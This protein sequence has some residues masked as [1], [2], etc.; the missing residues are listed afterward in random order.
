MA[1]IKRA[2]FLY[3]WALL[4]LSCAVHAQIQEGEQFT[5]RVV[6]VSDGDTLTVQQNGKHIVVRLAEIDAPEPAQAYGREATAALEDLALGK[7]AVVTITG[8]TPG[9]NVLAWVDVGEF[10]LNTD[11]V[12]YGHAWADRRSATTLGLYRAERQAQEAGRGLWALEIGERVPPWEW[13]AQQGLGTTTIANSV[14][15]V[16]YMH[17][18]GMTDEAIFQEIARSGRCI[19][20]ADNDLSRMAAAG[21]SEMLAYALESQFRS[22]AA[23]GVA[24]DRYPTT[25][26]YYDSPTYG[27]NPGL[28]NDYYG[29]GYYSPR[30]FTSGL[31]PRYAFVYSNG[32]RG[33]HHRNSRGHH[34]TTDHGHHNRN[35]S[36]R[37]KHAR[38]RGNN[39]RT[40]N[41][42]ARSAGRNRGNALTGNNNRPNNVVGA[43]TPRPAAGRTGRQGSA[44]T[45]RIGTSTVIPT[46]RALPPRVSPAVAAQNRIAGT[47]RRVRPVATGNRGRR[48]VTNTPVPASVNR[49]ALTRSIPVQPAINTQASPRPAPVAATQRQSPRTQ[50]RAW[51]N[52]GNQRFGTTPT[53]AASPRPAARPTPAPS[54]SAGRATTRSSSSR[55]TASRSTAPHRSS[56]RTSS[57]SRSAR[58]S[59]RGRSATTSSRSSPA[60]A[61]PSRRTSSSMGSGYRS[62]GTRW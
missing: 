10:V 18:S 13:R 24:M 60:R 5:A 12:R 33:D 35:G 28:Y 50:R 7:Q 16:I 17:Q 15:D 8:S 9:G 40:G 20:I 26:I 51:G 37:N 53:T 11:M 42:D 44:R 55:H 46:N 45:P 14:D 39:T 48:A 62:R 2:L 19:T 34:R 21:V 59:S 49:S 61:A 22:C 4:T 57:R 25:S 56:A 38:K 3:S 36:D 43:R 31:F 23:P 6:A 52:Y 27:Y 29:S 54:T 58:T 47:N 30:Y 32:A 1:R 41:V